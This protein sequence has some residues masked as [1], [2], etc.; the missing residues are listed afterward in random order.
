MISLLR[1]V[2]VRGQPGAAGIGGLLRDNN[3]KIL[4]KFS[5]SVGIADSNLAE[6]MAIKEAFE[7]FIGSRW[8][9]DFRLAIESD[10]ANVVKWI[11]NPHAIPW[12][13]REENAEADALAKAGV[14]RS[15]D[16]IIF[17]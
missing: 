15:V 17:E 13:F 11:N 1:H 3:S 12:R 9:N 2:C 7:L 10:S 8:A 14:E 5:K 6:L 16:L 4:L